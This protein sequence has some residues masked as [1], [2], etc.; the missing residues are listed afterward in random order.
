M[1]DPTLAAIRLR[2]TWLQLNNLTDWQAT[3]ACR[4]EDPEVFFPSPTATPQVQHAKAICAA[5]PVRLKCL[6]LALGNGLDHGIF[7]GFTEQERNSLLRRTAAIT[8]NKSLAARATSSCIAGRRGDGPA[9]PELASRTRS[10]G[11]DVVVQP[12]Q[13]GRI[14]GL[15]DLDQAR[16]ALSAQHSFHLDRPSRFLRRREVGHPALGGQGDQ[17]FGH[18][19]EAP[20][21]QLLGL[22][23]CPVSTLARG[24]RDSGPS[25]PMKASAASAGNSHREVVLSQH[26]IGSSG[27][28]WIRPE[29][30][31]GRSAIAPTTARATARIAASR[32]SAS[33]SRPRWQP[34][35]SDRRGRFFRQA[36][37]P[38]SPGVQDFG[39]VGAREIQATVDR[40]LPS[41]EDEPGHPA[42]R[43]AREVVGLVFNHVVG[44]PGI[45]NRTG[46]L[47]AE[48]AHVLESN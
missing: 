27:S 20:A 19:D 34:L 16:V 21:H 42:A 38:C 23:R 40:A 8:A 12:K 13:V 44:L 36:D 46:N 3:A 7:G 6:C 17:R 41:P 1:T 30:V 11:S 29:A 33:G 39:Q 28:S 48:D 31:Q 35:H 10:A 37:D 24:E 45:E 14:V 32:R 47:L 18:C 4:S 43:A 25:A 22:A 26:G 9:I 15:L 5:C 2:N